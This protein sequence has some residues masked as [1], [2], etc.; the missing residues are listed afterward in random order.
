MNEMDLIAQKLQR[1][2]FRKSRVDA[3][4]SD[5]STTQNKSIQIKT[6]TKKKLI[7]IMIEFIYVLDDSQRSNQAKKSSKET[8]GGS[9]MKSTTRTGNFVI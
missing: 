9:D 7:E 4:R 3:H 8:S 6:N 1:D 5:L 2:L